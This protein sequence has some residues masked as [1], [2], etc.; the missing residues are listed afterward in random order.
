M[1]RPTIPFLQ[2]TKCSSEDL[3]TFGGKFWK[4]AKVAALEGSPQ[5]FNQQNKQKGERG[6]PYLRPL[7]AWKVM[8]GEPLTKIEKKA[9]EMRLPIHFTQSCLNPKAFRVSFKKLKLT[10][11]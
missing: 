11:S 9:V 10:L 4:G 6:S 2:E 5:S 1:E 8:E 7:E 3:E